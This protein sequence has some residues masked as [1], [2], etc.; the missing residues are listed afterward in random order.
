MLLSFVMK[1]VCLPTYL[2]DWI[3]DLCAWWITEVG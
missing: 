2:W 3:G 1:Q